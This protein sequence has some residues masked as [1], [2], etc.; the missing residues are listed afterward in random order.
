MTTKLLS[1][2]GV[3]SAITAGSLYLLGVMYGQ[4]LFVVLSSTVVAVPLIFMAKYG[5]T[6][7]EF[8]EGSQ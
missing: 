7:S 3:P 5:H 2:V 8:S 1:K 4:V 6:L